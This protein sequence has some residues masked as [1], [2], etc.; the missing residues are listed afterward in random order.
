MGLIDRMLGR[1]SRKDLE[2]ELADARSKQ[3]RRVSRRYRAAEHSRL[4]QD[5][6]TSSHS[7]DAEIKS[8][9]T[10]LRGRAR[11]ITM[12]SAYGKRARKIVVD[13][14]IGS[15]IGMQGN[16]KS[17]RG[18]LM[19]TINSAIEDAWL[20]WWERPDYMHTGGALAAGDFER[21]VLSGVFDGGEIFV[22]MHR[23]AFS[24]SP[25]PLALEVIEPER[26][27]HEIHPNAFA[28][29]QR[30]RMGIEVDS[31]FRAEAYYIRQF[32]PSD[33]QYPAGIEAGQV[34]RV[35][36]DE[37]LHIRIVERWPQTR[38]VPWLHA[39]AKKLNDMDGYSDAE[40]IA[41]RAS[42]NYMMAIETDPLSEVGEEDEETG[43]LELGL[44]PG[45][46]LR[47]N[48]GEKANFFSPNRPNTAL[49][50]FMRYML[51]EVAA[52][53]DVS[54]ESVSRDYSQSNYSSSRLSL[55]E[56]RDHY[57]HLQ[58]W[59]INTLRLPIHR[60]FIQQA[61]LARAIEKI[62]VSDYA[63]NP[64]KFEA[65]KFKPRGWG[66]VDPTKEIAAYKEAEKAGYKT[67]TQIIA[68][69]GSG[70]DL[71][72]TIDERALELEQIE[73]A[74]VSFDTDAPGMAPATDPEPTP[75]PDPDADLEDGEDETER[76][77]RL[78]K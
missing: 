43:D 33:F 66:W 54:Y 7:A 18:K 36:A 26:V 13:N 55:L 25:V 35:R 75:D 78:I 20:R 48:T 10:R 64:E 11:S 21:A 5:W 3:P 50:P 38:G 58:R 27:P 52:G 77:M 71:Q 72:D 15:G 1:P 8:D 17:V 53:A 69:T 9:L 40:I 57:R 47:L 74:G 31:F 41:A 24:R 65:A 46:A 44:E 49:D 45:L 56:D 68:E 51:R 61:V 16:V 19:K 23:R 67:K 76:Q 37:I 22:R 60:A 63:L 28:N 14:V 6:S 70:Q 4:T 34:E 62:S 73:E 32:H 12:N 39:V 59:I 30:V 29:A 2:N 42:A